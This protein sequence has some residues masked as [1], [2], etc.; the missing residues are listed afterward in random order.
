MG[1]YGRQWDNYKKNICSYFV[2]IYFTDD[3]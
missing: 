3:A 2:L 1:L